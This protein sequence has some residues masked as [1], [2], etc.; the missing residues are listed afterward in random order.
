MMR[1]TFG[2]AQPE[3]ALRLS[4]ALGTTPHFWFAIQVHY[5]LWQTKNKFRGKVSPIVNRE[6]KSPDSWA[7]T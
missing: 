7:V 4:K 2:A 5:D 3:M 6:K 1:A